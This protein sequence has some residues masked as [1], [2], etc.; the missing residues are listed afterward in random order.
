MAYSCPLADAICC[1][2]AVPYTHR[3]TYDLL[4]HFHVQLEEKW[5]LQRVMRC[6][7]L[8]TQYPAAEQPEE[9]L[10]AAK[11][12][13]LQVVS[14]QHFGTLPGQL[15]LHHMEG[16]VC[17]ALRM[18]QMSFCYLMCVCLHSTETYLYSHQHPAVSFSLCGVFDCI[19]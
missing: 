6:G 11:N 14:S 2:R 8:D 7:A 17:G 19:R 5:D 10:T 12:W 4:N 1:G 16:S 15:I 13:Q 3:H 18:L 9:L